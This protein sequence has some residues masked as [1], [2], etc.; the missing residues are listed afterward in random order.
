MCC[1]PRPEIHAKFAQLCCPCALCCL[2]ASRLLF[3]NFARCSRDF[4]YFFGSRANFVIG[5][6]CL[7]D[8]A[9]LKA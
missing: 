7:G 1:L 9:L 2:F 5:G 8:V 3:S 4:R 6:L